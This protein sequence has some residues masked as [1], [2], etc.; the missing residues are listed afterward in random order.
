LGGNEGERDR[1][2]RL[3]KTD[4]HGV[5]TEGFCRRGRIERKGYGKRKAQGGERWVVWRLGGA[6]ELKECGGERKNESGTDRGGEKIKKKKK[7]GAGHDK[8]TRRCG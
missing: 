2:R 7:W 8:T 4:R 3:P 5:T 6:D 1:R